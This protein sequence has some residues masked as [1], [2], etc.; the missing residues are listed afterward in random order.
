MVHSL[1]VDKHQTFMV[2]FV[3]YFL[4]DLSQYSYVKSYNSI[5]FALVDNKFTCTLFLLI[6]ESL[7]KTFSFSHPLIL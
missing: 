5:H 6:F 1:F 4:F 7:H 3:Y 2:F